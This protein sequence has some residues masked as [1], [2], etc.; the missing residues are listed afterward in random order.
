MDHD[1]GK[2]VGQAF[3]AIQQLHSDISRLFRELEEKEYK[4]W[5]S[6][7]GSYYS[8]RQAPH[9]VLAVASWTAGWQK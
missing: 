7:F 6:V 3:Q 8:G 1:Y 5:Q 9:T 4:G 2:K